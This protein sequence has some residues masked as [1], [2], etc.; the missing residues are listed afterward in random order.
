MEY[1]WNKLDNDTSMKFSME[2]ELMVEEEALKQVT[3]KDQHSP[4]YAF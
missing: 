1:E 2:V 4:M 3:G